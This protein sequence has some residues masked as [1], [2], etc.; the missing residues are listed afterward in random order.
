[1]LLDNIG[2]VRCGNFKSFFFK[3]TARYLNFTF[4]LLP[5]QSVDILIVTEY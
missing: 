2:H 1:M 5:L 3:C 4:I